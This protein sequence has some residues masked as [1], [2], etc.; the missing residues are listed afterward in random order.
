[1]EEKRKEKNYKDVQKIICYMGNNT[2]KKN[3][4]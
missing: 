2:Y 4:R 1:M 3:W